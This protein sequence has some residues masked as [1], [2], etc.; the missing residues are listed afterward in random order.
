VAKQK[1]DEF[2]SAIAGGGPVEVFCKIDPAFVDKLL[3]HFAYTDHKY[4]EIHEHVQGLVAVQK[5]KTT[6]PLPKAEQ[7]A[8]RKSRES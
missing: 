3:H 2:L 1:K 6:Q 4:A 8:E 7:P 5:T